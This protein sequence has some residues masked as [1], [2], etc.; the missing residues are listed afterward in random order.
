MVHILFGVLL[1]PCR[2][3]WLFGRPL[4]FRFKVGSRFG[5]GISRYAEFR[6][7]GCYIGWIGRFLALSF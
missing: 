1:F 2:V 3:L 4:D 6:Y 7:F 5:V